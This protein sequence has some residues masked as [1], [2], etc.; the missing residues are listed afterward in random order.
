MSFAEAVR[1]FE[2]HEFAIRRSASVIIQSRIDLDYLC[3]LNVAGLSPSQ[4]E[5]YSRLKRELIQNLVP[6]EEELPD[7]N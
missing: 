4:F 1:G 3:S 6:G 7:L 5:R 2:Q